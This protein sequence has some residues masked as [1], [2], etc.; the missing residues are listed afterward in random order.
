VLIGNGRRYG[1]E[2]QLF[3]T[4][5]LRDGLLDVCVFP[6]VNLG[7]LVR[8]APGLMLRGRLPESVVVRLRAAT[9]TLSAA[10]PVAFEVEGELGGE[11]PATFAVCPR[12]LRVLIP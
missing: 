7:R 11:L 5:D 4:A 12:A 6:R 10:A 2:F 1:G 9:F 3:P 8:C